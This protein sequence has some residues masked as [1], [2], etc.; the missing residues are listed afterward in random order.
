[1]T[2]N[3][4]TPSVQT[5]VLP[6]RYITR[7]GLPHDAV[8]L[9]TE[10]YL[11]VNDKDLVTKVY[12]SGIDDRHLTTIMYANQS[13]FINTLVEIAKAYPDVSLKV[14]SK[15]SFPTMGGLMRFL[16]LE[17]LSASQSLRFGVSSHGQ[18]V[19]TFDDESELVVL[20]EEPTPEQAMSLMKAMVSRIKER[21]FLSQQ[22]DEAYQAMLQLVTDY[23][24]LIKS[25]GDDDD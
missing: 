23:G 25:S 18:M 10:R 21:Q 11:G 17:E 1:M 2:D 16:N 12:F 6:N 9:V 5:N 14:A 19:A 13:G 8:E 3:Q 4:F 20:S 7:I 24:I 22:Y 15:S